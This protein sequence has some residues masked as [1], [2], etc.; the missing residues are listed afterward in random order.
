MFYNLGAS[1]DGLL[2]N[3]G[4]FVHTANMALFRIPPNISVLQF[5]SLIS[6]IGVIT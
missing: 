5:C 2:F 4:I 1:I 3:F 6:V